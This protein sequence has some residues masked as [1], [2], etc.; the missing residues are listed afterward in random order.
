MSL[1]KELVSGT[2]YMAIAKYS[3]MVMTILISAILSRLLTPE[4]YGVAA[5]ATVMLALFNLFADI[6]IGP[7]VI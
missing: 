1:K 5:L 7:A 4:N 6:G 3:G 2:V